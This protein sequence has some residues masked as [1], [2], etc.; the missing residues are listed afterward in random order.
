MEIHPPIII[1]KSL[2]YVFGIPLIQEMSK[3]HAVIRNFMPTHLSFSIFLVYL[4][5]TSH[6]N[7]AIWIFFFVEIWCSNL[8]HFIF[9]KTSF[10]MAKSY[11]SSRI[12]AKTVATKKREKQCKLK[13]IY[14]NVFCWV[15]ECLRLRERAARIGNCVGGLVASK[16]WSWIVEGNF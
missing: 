14:T 7:L 10:Y 4:L 1:E 8:G 3:Y 16:L 12:L 6:K 9:M 13:G 5:R 11:F 2:W 15:H